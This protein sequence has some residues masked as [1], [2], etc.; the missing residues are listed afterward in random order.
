M[1]SP[2]TPLLEPSSPLFPCSSSSGPSSSKEPAKK[3][4]KFDFR[5]SAMQKFDNISK[6]IVEH[7]KNCEE[8]ERE[9]LEIERKKAETLNRIADDA[10]KF[11]DNLFSFLNKNN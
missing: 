4:R 9:L 6:E 8:N 10:K 7:L 3:K 5:E 11:S 1:P 2:A